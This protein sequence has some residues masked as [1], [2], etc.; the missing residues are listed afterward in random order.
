MISLKKLPR[1]LPFAVFQEKVGSQY[2]IM[3]LTKM[4]LFLKVTMIRVSLSI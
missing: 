3:V 1:L 2:S 4:S